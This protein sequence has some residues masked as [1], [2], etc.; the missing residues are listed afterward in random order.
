[1]MSAYYLFLSALLKPC[2]VR[3][4]EYTDWFTQL[5]LLSACLAAYE[6]GDAA[7]PTSCDG[8]LDGLGEAG[9]PRVPKLLGVACMDL[10]L[11]VSQSTIQA[12]PQWPTFWGEVQ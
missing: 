7:S 5:P 4:T 1:M 8:G 10:S 6:K 3:W 12:H 11:I 2:R 9:D